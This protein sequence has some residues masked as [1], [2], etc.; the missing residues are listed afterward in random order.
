MKVMGFFFFFFNCM[1]NQLLRV[2][3]SC[4]STP[5]WGSVVPSIV[6][7]RDQ[8]SRGCPLLFSEWESGIFLCIGVRNTVHTQPLGNH[9]PLQE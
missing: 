7:M 4:S 8:N 9:G 3:H 2:Q 1:F 5:S 6:E